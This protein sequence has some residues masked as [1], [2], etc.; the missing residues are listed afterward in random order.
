MELVVGS[1]RWLCDILAALI[2]VLV[3][4]GSSAMAAS[5]QS[6]PCSDPKF[7]ADLQQAQRQF[8]QVIQQ[9]Y[10]LPPEGRAVI[11]SGVRQAFR[12]SG[13][14][15]SSIPELQ[16]YINQCNKSS[17]PL[18]NNSNASATAPVRTNQ[19][20]AA[21]AN[22]GSPVTDSAP[23]SGSPS[24]QDKLASIAA[25]LK[26]LLGKLAST[27]TSMKPPVDNLA[28]GAASVK[29]ALGLTPPRTA[30]QGPLSAAE[31]DGVPI[32]SG[33]IKLGWVLYGRTD[34]SDEEAQ[35]RYDASVKVRTD[36]LE[37]EA[38]DSK[39]R[40]ESLQRKSEKFEEA[41]AAKNPQK[42]VEV[43]SSELAEAKEQHAR[44][45]RDLGLATAGLIPGRAVEAMSGLSGAAE[46]TRFAARAGEA[47]AKG[48]RLTSD[49]WALA[50]NGLAGN[51]SAAGAVVGREIGLPIGVAQAGFALMNVYGSHLWVRSVENSIDQTTR[52]LEE[53]RRLLRHQM[54]LEAA[55]QQ[56][57]QRQ[58][59]GLKQ[60]GRY[61]D[62]VRP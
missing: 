46:L 9:Y 22:S 18:G 61:L 33:K 43:L 26:Q 23:A 29:R 8:A 30:G 58:I 49:D 39:A 44:N 50:A 3:I 4:S 38:R 42:T 16:R 41:V 51:V 47:V 56:S 12:G 15:V 28:S 2:V 5:A 55:R 19:G 17:P 60:E 1:R 21:K 62:F 10:S 20:P 48:D 40:L 36:A 34:L 14:S 37:A 24:F 31:S 52:P 45:L 54:E 11:D 59:E 13:Y 6:D 25:Y 7:R 53:N 57:I 27:A 32:G 35:A